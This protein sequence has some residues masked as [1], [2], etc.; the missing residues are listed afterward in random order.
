ML[1]FTSLSASAAAPS[2]APPPTMT[3]LFTGRGFFIRAFAVGNNGLVLPDFAQ[4]ETVTP[5]RHAELKH[6]RLAM[7]AALALPAQEL[8]HPRICSLLSCRDMLSNGV[9]PN[10]LNGGIF[11]PE[12]APALAFALVVFATVECQDIISR[13]SQ[14]LGFNEWS[15]DSVAGDLGFDPLGI[16]RDL[17][18]TEKFE[19]QEAEMLNGRVAM[20][21]LAAFVA[22]EAFT[23]SPVISALA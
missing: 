15:E 21:A 9:S 20:L 7:L 5:L 16:A 2:R 4:P 17:P 19:L 11:Q 6:G 3:S 14:G 1:S 23:G 12:V 13:S 10:G 22:Y 18:A 8:L